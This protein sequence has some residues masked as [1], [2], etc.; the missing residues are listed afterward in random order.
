MMPDSERTPPAVPVLAQ[1]AAWLTGLGVC[2]YGLFHEHPHWHR[3]AV[4]QL[5]I[6]AIA[7]ACWGWH[8]MP[9]RTPSAG[10]APLR[11][12]LR[13]VVAI[14]VLMAASLA[15]S[16]W[17]ARQVG[18]DDPPAYH[19]EF[20]YLF[21][22]KTFLAGR[23]WFP[24]HPTHP[25]LFDQMHVLNDN[26]RM[27]SRYF[28]GTGLW[29]APFVAWGCPYVGHWLC[30]MLATAF[31]Y[32]AACELANPR[33]GWI[34]GGLIALSPGLALFS[35]LLLAHHPTLAGLSFFL[36]RMSRCE[37]TAAPRDA[38]GAGL[39]LTWAMLCRP[40]T[41]AGFGLP[42]GIGTLWWLVR[43]GADVR[44]KSAVF[45]GFAVPIAA[46]MA[47]QLGY[48]ASITGS[49]WRSPYQLYT[50]IYTPR[51][52]Y[53]FNNVVEGERRLGPKVLEDYDRWAENLDGRLA[54][55][56][57]A[58]RLGYSLW[59]T[60][61]VVPLSMLG[62]VALGMLGKWD[63]RRRLL[64]AAIASLHFVHVPYWFSGIMHW[65]YVF[66]SSLLW[67]VVGG[68]T[69]DELVADWHRSSRRLMPWWLATLAGVATA[70][71]WVSLPDLWTGKVA[72]EAP[73][74]R[75]PRRIHQHFREWT[76]GAAANGPAL[77]LVAPHRH[78]PHLDFVVNEP[79]L[80]SPVLYGRYLP[81]KTELEVLVRD[82]PER[83]IYVCE[84]DSR[85]LRRVAA[86][87]P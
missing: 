30:G 13:H 87:P 27:A 32:A 34:A 54:A 12:P 50:D 20:S 26:G 40:M 81:G 35:N 44:R 63:V 4:V 24:G 43:G 69:I 38:L 6:L 1:L 56:N 39:G 51:H 49:P 75:S 52:R 85:L 21:Q 2:L 86:A 70:G 16:V 41:A 8:R 45:L 76:G 7:P 84:P 53:G 73:I 5:V 9:R 42:F 18:W 79:G 61:D 83:A 60:W 23:T 25:E 11:S 77:V 14:C 55:K 58:L 59:W 66:E 72:Q 80:Q 31:V 82:L 37:R 46:G 62:A 47:V 22:A 65:H 71:N 68:L 33:S 57:V 10:K 15:M 64:L 3:S 29:L 67:A 17:T 36:W 28:P 19:D 74:I 48:N 78:L